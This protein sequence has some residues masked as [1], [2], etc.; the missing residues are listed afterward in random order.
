MTAIFCVSIA[1][2]FVAVVVRVLMHFVDNVNERRNHSETQA[3]LERLVNI[4]TVAMLA[5]CM[6][7]YALSF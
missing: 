2:I 1:V 4:L 6:I 3:G 5:L 7:W